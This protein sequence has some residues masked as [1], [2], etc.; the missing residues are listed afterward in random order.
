[1]E[2]E[3]RGHN[4]PQSLSR[5]GISCSANATNNHVSL[6]CATRGRRPSNH[7]SSPTITFGPQRFEFLVSLPF[8][9]RKTQQTGQRFVHTDFQN[10]FPTTGSDSLNSSSL[11]SCVQLRVAL[12]C[13]YAPWSTF[14]DMPSPVCSLKTWEPPSRGFACDDEYQASPSRCARSGPGG[15]RKRRPVA[16]RGIMNNTGSMQDHPRSTSTVN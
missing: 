4:T 6:K 11:C 12:A 16:L 1:M 3:V 15:R 13:V 10:R 5:F 7:P 2:S 14:G 9:T 8:S